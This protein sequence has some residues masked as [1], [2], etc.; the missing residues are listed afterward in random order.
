MANV[1]Q[2][3]RARA[4]GARCRGFETPRSPHLIKKNYI[5]CCLLF[6]FIIKAKNAYRSRVGGIG[7][8][9]GFRYQWS[10]P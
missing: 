10:N 2:L 9:A 6:H 4:C 1:A 5:L 3:V 7:I 8:R